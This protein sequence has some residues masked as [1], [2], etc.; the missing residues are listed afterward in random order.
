MMKTT[1]ERSDLHDRER[2]DASERNRRKVEQMAETQMQR[3]K[4][5]KR[6][7]QAEEDRI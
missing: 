5:R 7:G 6:A 4:D 3:L 1:Q 2:R